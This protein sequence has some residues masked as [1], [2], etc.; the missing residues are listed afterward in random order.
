MIALVIISILLLCL[1]LFLASE[2]IKKF[3]FM[4][5]FVKNSE[6]MM[7]WKYDGKRRPWMYTIVL[8][9][10]QSFAVLIGFKLRIFGW[11]GFDYY[12][13]AKS[14]RD[15]LIISTYLGRNAKDF[16]FFSDT[17]L[18]INPIIISSTDEEQKL[19]AHKIY[20]PHRYQRLGFYG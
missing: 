13:F 18:Q 19:K 11:S 16:Y 1:T 9:G 10:R 17:N 5:A 12:G 4:Q 6:Q 15:T 7:V 2:F 8:R 3:W 20:K 14:N